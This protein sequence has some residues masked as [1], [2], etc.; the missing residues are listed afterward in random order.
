MNTND[1]IQTLKE[2][3]ANAITHGAGFIFSLIAI[4]FLIGFALEKG[5]TGTVWSVS[6]FSFGMLMIYLSSTLYHV[7]QN[8]GTKFKLRIWDHVSIFFMIAGSYTPILQKYAD[9]ATATKFL[10]A[11]WIIAALGVIMKLF[12]TGR[13]EIFSILLYLGMGWIAV[14][15]VEPLAKVI[16][17]DI[18]TLLIIG[19]LSYTLGIIFYVWHSLTYQHAIWHVFVLG[20]SVTHYFAIYYSVPFQL[21]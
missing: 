11:L 8:P 21:Q 2:E 4:P 18:L 5:S 15:I 10:T 13:Y 20:G 12:F 3:V 16:P 17:S 7:V 9:D 19:G 6:V 14:F 1:R